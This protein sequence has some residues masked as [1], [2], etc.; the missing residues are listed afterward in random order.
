MRSIASCVEMR[1]R[2]YATTCSVTTTLPKQ[3]SRPSRRSRRRSSRIAVSLSSFAIV[4][5]S[6]W[7]GVT[8]AVRPSRSSVRHE[9]RL[10]EMQVDGAVVDGRVRALELDEAEQRARLLLDDRDRVGRG[11]AQRDARGGVVLARPRR[12][13]PACASARG[14]GPRARAPRR[15]A[16]RGR[17]RRAGLRTRPRARARRARA[18]SRGRGSPPRR[19]GRAARRA[20]A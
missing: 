19:A 5:Q 9:V 11:R 10:A 3:R 17:R 7:N 6:P 18:G 8:S 2:W 1:R 4:Y 13:R 14:A 16:S 20:R 12:S 15:R